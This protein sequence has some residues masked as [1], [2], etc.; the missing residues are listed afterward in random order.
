MRLIFQFQMLFFYNLH[1]KV[2]RGIGGLFER[3][4]RFVARN[5][6][7]IVIVVGILDTALGL[8]LLKLTTGSGIDQYVPIGSTASKD[9]T[10][11]YKTIY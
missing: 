9:Q 1:H 6:W 10:K 8:G 11:V 5:P 3:Y 7:K 4:G 2:E